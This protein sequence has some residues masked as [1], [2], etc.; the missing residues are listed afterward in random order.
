[1]VEIRQLKKR[2]GTLTVLDGV[3]LAIEPGQI[4]SVV[5][6]NAAGKSTLLKCMVGLVHADSGE[7]L[8]DGT[9]IN[10][11]WRYRRK[12]GYVPQTARFPEDLSVREL[13]VLIETL[14][15]APAV[16]AERIVTLFGLGPVMG[17][18]LRELS[19]G[20]RQ[21]VSLTIAA[22]F[23]P[24][25]YIMDEPTVGF[26]PLVSRRQREWMVEERRRGK[27]LVV[28]SHVMAEVEEL[29]DRV[30]FMLYGKVCFDGAPREALEGTGERSLER[31]IAKMM[32]ESGTCD[33]P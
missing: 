1:M 13:I 17:R 31:A 25:L 14:R 18:P 21:K 27:T 30:I 4:V 29:S 23:D 26:D 5:G 19:G 12:I 28:A 8:I 24:S 20:T 10:G 22:M 6:P 3:N 15:G 9:V 7:I 11:D 2:F 32:E 16:A 33:R